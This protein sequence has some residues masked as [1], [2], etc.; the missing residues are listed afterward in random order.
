ME[1]GRFGR[2]DLTVSAICLGTM[3]WG[4]STARRTVTPGWT[5]R[6]NLG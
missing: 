1:S 6:W 4:S 2:T 5:T 3:T